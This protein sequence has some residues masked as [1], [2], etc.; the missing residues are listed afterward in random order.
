VNPLDGIERL[1]VDGSNL[2]HAV[3][4]GAL[5][6]PATALVGR[7]RAA[8]PPGIAVHIVFDGAPDRGMRNVRIASG[9]TVQHSGGRSGDAI[10]GQ[11]ARASVDLVVTDD[12]ELRGWLAGHGV[13]T[14]GT[15]WLIDRLDRPTNASPTTG[16]RRPPRTPGPPDPADAEDGDVRAGWRPGRGATTK[17]GNPWRRRR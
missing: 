9:V 13:A 10:I 11:I 16:N 2:A 5:P 15:D 6:A 17:R 8:T 14:I 4:R 7:L 12:R 3:R 1:V